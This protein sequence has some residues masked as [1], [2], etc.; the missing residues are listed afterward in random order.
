MVQEIVGHPGSLYFTRLGPDRILFMLVAKNTFLGTFVSLL[1]THI[2]K[3]F[4]IGWDLLDSV[5]KRHIQIDLV[6]HLKYFF[7]VHVLIIVPCFSLK[8]DIRKTYR[9][10]SKSEITSNSFMKNKE[11]YK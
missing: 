3:K 6:K 10:G 2:L 11:N 9:K 8:F 4:G 1:C 5:K 7:H